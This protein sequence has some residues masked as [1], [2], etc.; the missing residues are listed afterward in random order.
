MHN[1]LLITT[2]S[3]ILLSSGCQ[4]LGETYF[5][6]TGDIQSELTT[7]EPCRLSLFEDEKHIELDWREVGTQIQ[8]G[9]VLPT[10][11]RSYFFE[12]A[13]QG[14]QTYTS[15]RYTLGISRE[16]GSTISLGKIVLNKA[17]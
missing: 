10:G 7:N 4:M 5:N 9:F 11:D 13:C 1:L 8:T 3:L 2:T 17:E 6:I 14:F 16:F 15:P 12:L